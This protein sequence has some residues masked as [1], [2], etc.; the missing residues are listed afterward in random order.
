M[1]KSP[2]AEIE[3]SWFKL[4]I[5]NNY[6]PSFPRLEEYLKT[7]GR[8]KLIVPL[9]EALM[10]TPAGAEMAKRV[11]AKARPGYHPETVKAIEAIVVSERGD[12]RVSAPRVSEWMKVMLEEIARKQAEEEQMRAEDAAAARGGLRARASN[13]KVVLQFGQ[14]TDE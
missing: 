12:E 6:Q 1:S 8:R 2:N 7:I 13:R 3:H 11:F 5:A 9:Y 4:V 14:C 10:K